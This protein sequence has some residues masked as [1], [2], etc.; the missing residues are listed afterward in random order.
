MLVMPGVERKTR[1]VALVQLC[2][3]TAQATAEGFGTILQRFDADLRRSL[4]YDQGREM[5]QHAKLTRG[6]PR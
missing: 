6:Y 1:Y 3:G 2:N 5:S 4:T